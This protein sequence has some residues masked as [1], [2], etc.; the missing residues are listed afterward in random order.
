MAHGAILVVEDHETNRLYL[1]LLLTQSG[2]AVE[3]AANGAEAL[4]WLARRAFDLVLMDLQMPVM[5]GVEAV[6]R[7]RERER[8]GQL[9]R[10]PVIAVSAHVSEQSRRD[11]A[12]AGMDDF[13]A[14]PFLP[15]ELLDALARWLPQPR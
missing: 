13:L 5:G 8:V 10:T 3:T 6:R 4:E 1:G 11:S 12:A 7:L 15:D 14:K 9:S 2:Y